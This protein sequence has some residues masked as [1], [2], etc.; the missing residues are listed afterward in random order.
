MKYTQN[1]VKI[2]KYFPF[3]FSISLETLVEIS[4]KIS[5]YLAVTGAHFGPDYGEKHRRMGPGGRFCRS[6]NVPQDRDSA[7][8]AGAAHSRG[9]LS[10]NAGPRHPPPCFCR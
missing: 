10:P 2:F 8:V 5:K 9:H 1:S 6:D 7:G 4:L 3:N